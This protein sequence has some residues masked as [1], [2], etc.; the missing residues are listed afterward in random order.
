MI[1]TAGGDRAEWVAGRGG[2]PGKKKNSPPRQ[3]GA[4]AGG[5]EMVV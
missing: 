4:V 1:V 2:E 3:P 5:K